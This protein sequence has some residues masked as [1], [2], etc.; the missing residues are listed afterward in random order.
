M[1]EEIIYAVMSIWQVLYSGTWE[2]GDWD[3]E[4]NEEDA[5]DN[6]EDAVECAKK[7]ELTND[8]PLVRVY[9]RTKIWDGEYWDINDELVFEKDGFE[10]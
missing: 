1:T 6:L 5:F 10:E 4:T 3:W 7:F 8:M 2:D 9:K